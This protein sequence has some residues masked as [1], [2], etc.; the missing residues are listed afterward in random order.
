MEY[1][2]QQNIKKLCNF[3]VSDLHLAVMLLPYISKQ[4]DKDVEITTIF[5]RL[6]KK[7]IEEILEKLNIKNKNEILDINWL[8][9]NKHTDIEIKECIKNQINDG[10]EKI[11]IIGGN[12]NFIYH[13]NKIVLNSFEIPKRKESIKIID[14]Y[15]IEEVGIKAQDIVKQYDAIVNT[16]GEINLVEN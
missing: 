5:E 6:E 3:Y 4:I 13:N 11:F 14:C 12:K 1:V 10:K 2:G 16:S 8:N 7:N 15:N 9:S